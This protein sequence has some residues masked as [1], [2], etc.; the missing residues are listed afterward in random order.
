MAGYEPDTQQE[1]LQYL[2][3]ELPVLRQALWQALREEPPPVGR[4]EPLPAL[5]QVLWQALPP[6][7]RHVLVQA[8]PLLSRQE[9]LE[10]LLQEL[11]QELQ[12][13]PPALLQERQHE[14]PPEQRTRRLV[15]SLA[16]LKRQRGWR[17]QPSGHA[18]ADA[19]SLYFAL[20]TFGPTD[21]VDILGL[22][23][24]L[25]TA[26]G[27]EGL[28]LDEV[29][30]LDFPLALVPGRASIDDASLPEQK[31]FARLDVTGKTAAQWPSLRPQLLHAVTEVLDAVMDE[32]RGP[33]VRDDARHLATALRDYAQ[34][35]L[36]RP[37]FEHERIAAE[38]RRLY[39]QRER[40]RAEAREKHAEAETRE[41]NNNVRRFRGALGAAQALMLGD[42]D[43]EAVI[44]TTHVTALLD[45]LA[46]LPS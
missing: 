12:E 37:G 4:Q 1:L 18:S 34:A 38:V 45:M 5:R 7:R 36:A 46:K 2:R 26:I 14:L 17:G 20:D 42:T 40:D 9:I 13:L 41:C 27:G 23:A 8:L 35:H 11:L 28:V 16:R 33:T 32:Q 21:M 29:T 15:A 6:A 39:S 19:L 24:E 22:L 44:C 3:Q 30:F 25:S 31:P 10:E 43:D